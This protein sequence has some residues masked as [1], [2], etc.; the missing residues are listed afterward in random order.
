MEFGMFHEFPA[1][2]GRSQADAFTE[3]LEQ[4]EMADRWGLERCGAPCSSASH[5][6]SGPGG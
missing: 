6:A 1:L 3:A 2:A 5:I 4:C